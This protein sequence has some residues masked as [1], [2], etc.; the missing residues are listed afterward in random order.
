[1]P[2]SAYFKKAAL[3]LALA[4]G[5]KITLGEKTYRLKG[6]YVNTLAMKGKIEPAEPW[7]DSVYRT[8]LQCREGAFLDVGANVG[9]TMF[10]I[11]SLDSSRQYLGFEP[12]V[13]CCFLIQRFLEE[14]RIRNCAIFPIG[15]S[16]ANGTVKLYLRGGDYDTTASTVA[17]F[18]PDSFYTTHRYVCL[19]KGDELVSELGVTSISTIKIDVEGAEVEVIEGLLSV[20]EEKTPFIIFEVLNH[21]LVVTGDKLDAQHIRFRE[22]RIEKMEAILRTRGYEIFNIRA[23]HC[24]AKIRSIAPGTTADMSVTNYIAVSKADL[25]S[26]LRLFPGTVVDSQAE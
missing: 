14:N 17:N 8:V 4:R 24:L 1:M 21:F 13:P 20:I 18:R 11:L 19:R 26:F 25:D 10:K 3:A 12:Q 2:L 6:F 16:N 23:D 7:L 5:S 9:Q 22:T 15:L